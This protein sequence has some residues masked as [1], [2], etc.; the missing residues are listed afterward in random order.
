MKRLYSEYLVFGY[1]A[2][3]DVV[4]SDAPWKNTNGVVS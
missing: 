3:L 1:G 4:P 2:F